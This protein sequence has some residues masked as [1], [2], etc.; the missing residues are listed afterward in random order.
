[1]AHWLWQIGW[2]IAFRGEGDAGSELQVA[3][4]ASILGNLQR[5][6]ETL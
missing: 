5:F 1:M 3:S 4:R 6:G 2:R